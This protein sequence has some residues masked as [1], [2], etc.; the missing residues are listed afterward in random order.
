MKQ[1]QNG[2]RPRGGENKKTTMW[3]RIYA[4]AKGEAINGGITS[5]EVAGEFG[6]GARKVSAAV[7]QLAAS[8]RL[9]K[10]DT[11]NCY[12]G[13]EFVFVRDDEV[14]LYGGEDT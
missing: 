1:V 2:G 3:R 4:Y 6:V 5:A 7:S 11:V 13:R 8:G 12:R 9:V 14:D 10:V